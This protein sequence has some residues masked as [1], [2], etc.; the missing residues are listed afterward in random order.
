MIDLLLVR[1]GVTE[2]NSTGK[3][4]GRTDVPL[5]R[6]GEMQARQL[7]RALRE[8]HFDRAYASPLARASR[9]ARI[10]LKPHKM[11]AVTDDRLRECDF[12]AWEGLTWDQIVARWPF[13]RGRGS[14]SAEEYTPEGGEDFDAVCDRARSF[15]GELAANDDGRILVVTHAGVLHA[16]LA[17]LGS[18]LLDPPE[19]RLGLS[20]APASI[21]RITM[22]RERARI[23]V[24]ND[25]RHLDTPA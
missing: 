20:F 23:M 14:T 6:R 4:Q 3:F 8:Q 22:D 19:D 12:G 25:V 5:S 10:I 7:M 11:R 24:L 15:L 2:W 18:R 1:H 16:V 17:V 13:L 21:S 9:T